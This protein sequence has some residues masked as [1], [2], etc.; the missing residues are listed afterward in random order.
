MPVTDSSWI[1]EAILLEWISLRDTKPWGSFEAPIHWPSYKMVVSTE[2]LFHPQVVLD[3]IGF[4]PS[5]C[6]LSTEHNAHNDEFITD[7]IHQH[8]DVSCLHLKSS[9]FPSSSFGVMLW[10]FSSTL[11]TGVYFNPLLKAATQP[12]PEMFT[13]ATSQVKG[14]KCTWFI[15]YSRSF[16]GWPIQDEAFTLLGGK[17]HTLAILSRGWAKKACGNT[18]V[19]LYLGRIPCL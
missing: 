15:M 5:S 9:V 11:A 13:V 12:S 2:V 16:C 14:K 1:S 4:I 8:T 6:A 7:Q 19:R 10:H 3:E 17:K 18:E